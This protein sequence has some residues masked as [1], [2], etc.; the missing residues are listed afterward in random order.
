MLCLH[1]IPPPFSLDAV[2]ESHQITPNIFNRSG[3][4]S[5]PPSSAFLKGKLNKT[6]TQSY[7]CPHS[8]SWQSFSCPSEV[9]YPSSYST[10]LSHSHT[11][12]LGWAASLKFCLPH[13]LVSAIEKTL[14]ASQHCYSRLPGQE[15]MVSV[16]LPRSSFKSRTNAV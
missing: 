12:S 9:K 8:N 15:T 2:P 3:S 5:D 16:I 14:D 11:A 4:G 7:V 6:I 10:T 13:S 1:L